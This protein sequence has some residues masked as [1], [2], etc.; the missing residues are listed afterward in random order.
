MEVVL[1]EDVKA[2]GKK[3][4]DRKGQRRICKKLYP[5]EE[6]GRRGQ[7]KESERSEAPEGQR[8]Q[9]GCRAAGRGKGPGC[10]DRR[11]FG[12]SLHQ[13]RRGRNNFGSVSTKEIAKA[14]AD[15]LHLDIDKK[16]MVLTDP[17]RSLGTFEVPIKLHKGRN[18]KAESQ[19]DR[20]VRIW[21]K[22]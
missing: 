3:R 4:T 15:Q 2:L 17:I 20:G 1:L 13:G 5:A 11:A 12:D 14:A 19:G 10:K 6:V 7:H 16:K 22:R 8:S 9:G 21:K 18:C